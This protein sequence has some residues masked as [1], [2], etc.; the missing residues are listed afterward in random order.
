[1]AMP[2]DLSEEPLL[3]VLDIVGREASRSRAAKVFSILLG[4]L[5]TGFNFPANICLT[6]QI[7]MCIIIY[8]YFEL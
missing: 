5:D 7:E 1:M 2:E 3:T 8:I 4:N 6:K